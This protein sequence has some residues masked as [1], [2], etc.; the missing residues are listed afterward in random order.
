MVISKKSIIFQAFRGSN[1]FRGGGGGVQLFP[2]GGSN[3]FQGGRWGGVPSANFLISIETH[4]TC[5]FPGEGV[6]NP[7]P[8]PP[9]DLHMIACKCK[10]LC[11][12]FK[13]ESEPHTGKM[14]KLYHKKNLTNRCNL[15]ARWVQKPYYG[16]ATVGLVKC[17]FHC[18]FILPYSCL[19]QDENI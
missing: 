19:K 15:I 1:I 7:Y 12:K 2:G 17:T 5:D 13:T 6:R 9:L 8:P 14:Y 16:F 3:F 18:H 4:I 11:N 10:L